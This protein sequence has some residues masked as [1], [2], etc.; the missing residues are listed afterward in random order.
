MFG[1]CL[2]SSV[3]GLLTKLGHSENAKL[4][5]YWSV[6][7]MSSVPCQVSAS[8]NRTASSL[9]NRKLEALS[10]CEV[11]GSLASG[12]SH[13]LPASGMWVCLPDTN[14]SIHTLKHLCLSISLGSFCLFGCLA[15]TGDQ[16]C[17]NSNQFFGHRNVAWPRVLP[18]T[19]SKGLPEHWGS[20]LCRNGVPVGS[21]S[22]HPSLL[23]NPLLSAILGY[24]KKIGWNS[25][26]EDFKL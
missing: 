2:K 15:I 21:L 10:W 20:S 19:L 26:Q 23:R 7:G 22:T 11:P 6:H 12:H 18:A 17:T 9:E 14:V 8:W 4:S 1:I 13:L 24:M 25:G 3:K 16:S 5:S